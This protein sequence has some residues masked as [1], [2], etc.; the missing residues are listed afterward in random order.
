MMDLEVTGIERLQGRFKLLQER[1][2]EDVLR[3][4]A[5]AAG[6]VVKAEIEG[7]APVLDRKA[8]KS[9]ALDPGTLKASIAVLG[10]KRDGDG[11]AVATVGPK[12]EVA[13]VV[14]WVEFGHRL[15]RGGYS[16]VLPNGKTRGPGREV[17]TVRAHPFIRPAYENS[18]A[19][20]AKAA[21][22]VIASE[23]REAM[24]S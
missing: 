18:S 11:V 12:D 23:I 7:L 3:K 10:V 20:A 22:E 4:A 16:K 19:E 6:N 13:H 8:A 17:G 1:M 21:G 9:T 14:R 5:R 15:V 24:R 2:R